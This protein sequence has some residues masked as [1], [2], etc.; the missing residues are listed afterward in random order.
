MMRIHLLVS[1]MLIAV[2][3][4]STAETR[5]VVPQNNIKHIG[6]TT[7]TISEVVVTATRTPKLLKDVPYVTKVFTADDIR[8]ADATNIQELM[9]TIMPGV[10]FT[11]AMNQQ[12]TLN[13]AGFGGNAVLF[14]IDGERIAGETMDNPDYNRLTLEDVE[15]IEV[16]KGAAS[17]LYGSNAV[18]GVINI[19]TRKP[20]DRMS[21]N[22]F[23]HWSAFGSQKYGSV[24][25]FAR[26]K[27]S[28]LTTFQFTRI[29]DMNLQKKG[30]LSKVFG[31]RTW[32]IKE[33]LT[34]RPVKRLEMTAKTSYFFRERYASQD[35]HDRYRDLSASLKGNYK[36]TKAD[37]IELTYLFDEYD[38][39]DLN[40][41]T[42]KDIRDYNNTQNSVRTMY[43]HTFAGVGTLT[44][45]ADY[46]RDY[47]MSYQ[48]E[49][50]NSHTQNSADG[51]IQ[52]DW[53]PSPHWNMIGGLR[54]DY[55]SA[56]SKSRLSA[57]IGLM[58]KFNAWRFRGSYAGGFRAPSLK[59]LFMHF[60]MANVFT[61]YGNKNL[62]P[63]NSDNFQLSTEYTH[64]NYSFSVN[65]FHNIFR[66]RISTAWNTALNG[67]NY[68]NTA[69]VRI[70]GLDVN[71]QARFMC[72][73]G[74][75]AAY[76][77]THENIPMGQP[78]TSSTRPHTAVLRAD[79]DHNF[80]TWGFNV[81]LTGRYLSKLSTLQ[82]TSAT[83]YTHTQ[84]VTYPQYQIWRLTATGRLN[85][86]IRLT[87]TI[88]N[89]FNYI[90][91]YY[92]INSPTTTGAILSCGLSVD[93]DKLLK[94]K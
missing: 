38:K 64:R 70:T 66:N 7:E 63:E 53:D 5:P 36:L 50:D 65:A 44:A 12:T 80:R 75:T 29:N 22:V 19:I 78:Y 48:F 92:Y 88:D 28:S 83:S 73:V 81:A 27:V 4:V 10:E 87:T 72:G 42:R 9:T 76:V 31:N 20:H 39:S 86:G 59:E 43:N 3:S 41:Q 24:I 34:W 94:W 51:F 32:N 61:I 85:R 84:R 21:A 49:N 82:Y 62:K 30:D 1:A 47:L 60:N 54:Y 56:S 6:D 71:A 55:F 25:G 46:M 57:K 91:N 18:G 23:G 89:L 58:Y 35:S 68:L 37:N 2:T 13:M 33:K 77:F 17:S 45:G 26:P 69:K 15:R 8:K 90:P 79:Y 40:T 14:L 16:V 11:F 67:M 52:F 93:I 74:L